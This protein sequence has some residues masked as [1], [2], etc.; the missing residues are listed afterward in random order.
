MLALPSQ[1]YCSVGKALMSVAAAMCLLAA[2]G[3]ESRP[4]P[5]A[6]RVTPVVTTTAQVRQYG[7]T[8]EAIGTAYAR[9]SVLVTSR[10]SGRVSKIFLVEGASV[11]AGDPLVQ[12]ED[13]TERANLRSATAA[14]AEAESQLVRLKSLAERGLVSRL[15]LDRQHRAVEAAQAALELARV[16]LDQRTIRA[17]FAGVVGFRQVSLGSLVQPGTNIV[18][19]DACDQMRVHF[20]VPETLL[21]SIQVANAVQATTAAYPGRTYLGKITARGTRVDEMTRAVPAQAVFDNSDGSLLPGMMLTLQIEA[22]P[23][24]LT[25]VPEAALAPDNARQFIWKIDDTGLAQRVPVE[26]GVREQGWVEIVSGV[27]PGERVVVEGGVNL[28][29]GAMVREVTR[30]DA[31]LVSASREDS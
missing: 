12:L 14:A 20:S 31:T 28:R 25:Y 21:S 17:P 6:S 3:R 30:P 22:Q 1:R 10:V 15:E 27:V 4:A 7:A 5:R 8:V 9:E 29:P 2:C 24:E 13:D 16:L 11:A 26:I 18:T 23:R 19:L